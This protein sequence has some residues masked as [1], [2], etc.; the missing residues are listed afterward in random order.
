MEE[1]DKA[2]EQVYN[3]NFLLDYVS[4]NVTK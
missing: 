1:D 3:T 2:C 4:L